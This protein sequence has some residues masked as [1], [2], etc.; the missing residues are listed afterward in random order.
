MLGVTVH[1]GRRV[2]SRRG[3]FD[4]RVNTTSRPIRLTG[5]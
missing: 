1:R 5:G 2:P 3:A 4:L